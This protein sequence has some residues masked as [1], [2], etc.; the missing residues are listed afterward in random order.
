MDNL[1][2]KDELET[3]EMDA[4]ELEE[5]DAPIDDGA[6]SAIVSATAVSVGVLIT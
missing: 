2:L 5:M 1:D 6:V 4:Q 3:P